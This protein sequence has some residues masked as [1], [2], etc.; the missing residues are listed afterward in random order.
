MSTAMTSA[1][2][3]TRAP[4]ARGIRAIIRNKGVYAVTS[5]AVF[6]IS[7]GVLFRLDFIPE[8]S[9]LSDTKNAAGV[10]TASST[11]EVVEIPVES[12][13]RIVIKSVGVDVTVSNP[14]TTNV[15]SLDNALLKG[16]VRYP[17]SANL[18]EKGNVVIFGHS[19]Y[20][21]IVS[22]PNFKAFTAIEKLKKGDEIVV[23]G[24]E[25]EYH[26]EVY[27]VYTMKAD[28]GV[29]PLLTE[30]KVLTLSTCNTFG[31][32]QDRFV[33]TSTLVSSS[34]IAK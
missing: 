15:A 20:L 16:A 33:V 17:T 23:Y 30:G 4:L 24:D 5:I 6:I 18:G 3:A 12:P 21:P 1:R 29:I 13:T 8:S 14:T 9:A 31:T 28:N 27:N 26:Y 32:P 7:F 10:I 11:D 34:R 2:G 25:Y 22:N 19:T